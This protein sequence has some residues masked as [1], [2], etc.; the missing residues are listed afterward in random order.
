M[1]KT[2]PSSDP[3]ETIEL[4]EA[5]DLGEVKLDDAGADGGGDAVPP[6]L[7]ASPVPVEGVA[8]PSGET[9]RR[10][11]ALAVMAFLVLLV[12]AIV[13]GVQAGL[14]LRGGAPAA[15]GAALGGTNGAGALS[16]SPPV[17]SGAAITIPTI[18]MSDPPADSG[19]ER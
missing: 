19:T 13:G 8:A 15:S 3:N 1:K 5:V 16:A 2:E 14:A 9:V 10:R 7:P 6:P 18:E 12:A 4:D 17:P 11:S